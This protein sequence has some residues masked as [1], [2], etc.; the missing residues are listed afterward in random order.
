MVFF[1]SKSLIMK[2]KGKG[3]KVIIRVPNEPKTATPLD[4]IIVS[5]TERR[6]LVKSKVKEMDKLAMD[7]VD[8]VNELSKVVKLCDYCGNRPAVDMKG[9]KRM[10]ENKVQTGDCERTYVKPVKHQPRI[11]EKIHRNEPCHCG[12]G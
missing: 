10:C 12:S 9:N 3:G 7:T 5:E 1:R 2:K 11:S 6:K 4:A 8:A